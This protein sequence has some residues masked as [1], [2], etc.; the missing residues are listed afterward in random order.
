MK[1]CAEGDITVSQIPAGSNAGHKGERCITK[2]KA[3]RIV[4][5][6]LMV[7]TTWS[8]VI[9]LSKKEYYRSKGAEDG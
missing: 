9:I 2:T 4:L 6:V 5:K 1:A 8:A 7:N 3:Q